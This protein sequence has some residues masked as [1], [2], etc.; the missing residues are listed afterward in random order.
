MYCFKNADINSFYLIICLIGPVI[1]NK[2]HNFVAQCYRTIN[3]SYE[4]LQASLKLPLE[5]IQK[6]IQ[7]KMLFPIY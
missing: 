5:I 3:F 7:I 2:I 6:L 1:I 4:Q